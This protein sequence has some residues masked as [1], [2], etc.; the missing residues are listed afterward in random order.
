MV[1]IGDPT[2]L[3]LLDIN[4]TQEELLNEIIKD[5]C[6]HSRIPVFDETIDEIKGVL[7]V[8]DIIK[9][10]ALLKPDLERLNNG[11]DSI[12]ISA[13]DNKLNLS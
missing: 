8:K 5:E 12:V 13:S 10:I 2:E 1:R 11:F 3:A 6:R 9:N 4:M 7:Y